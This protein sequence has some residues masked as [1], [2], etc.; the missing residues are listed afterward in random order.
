[1]PSS[2]L[3]I[4]FGVGGGRAPWWGTLLQP[5]ILLGTYPVRATLCTGEHAGATQRGFK[6]RTFFLQGCHHPL[7]ENSTIQVIYNYNVK[8]ILRTYWYFPT[9]FLSLQ[10][11]MSPYSHW[12]ISPGRFCT[13]NQLGSTFSIKSQS[14]PLK[15][16]RPCDYVPP[17]RS[18][19]SCREPPGFKVPPQQRVLCRNTAKCPEDTSW[20]L[21]GYKNTK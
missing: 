16:S 5:A 15:S 3:F 12:D 9:L 21:W 19:S 18:S 1:M 4:Q 7:K 17:G 10:K 20:R 6:P 13:G 14:H 11:K 8:H 2:H